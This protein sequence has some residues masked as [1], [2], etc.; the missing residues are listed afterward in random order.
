MLFKD[1]DV[2]SCSFHIA[3][4]HLLHQVR[5]C[6]ANGPLQNFNDLRL[7]AIGVGL[8]WVRTDC[9]DFGRGCG[10]MCLTQPYFTLGQSYQDSILCYPISS[11]YSILLCCVS[12]FSY[13]YINNYLISWE[14]CRWRV[15]NG[16]RRHMGHWIERITAK[17]LYT[18]H[19]NTSRRWWMVR[20]IS[21]S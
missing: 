18:D 6:V 13:L 10:Q 1:S 16:F 21:S 3:T 2:G 7:L 4:G 11:E 20:I 14:R 19:W 8:P 9:V 5:C 12:M 15:W 17:S